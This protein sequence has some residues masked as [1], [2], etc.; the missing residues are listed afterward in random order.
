MET[1]KYAKL[2]CDYPLLPEGYV[3]L[4]AC[5]AGFSSVVAFCFQLGTKAW[6]ESEWLLMPVIGIG[7]AFSLLVLFER[8]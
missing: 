7:L 5:M 2:K 4:G 8:L 3:I 6:Q 1:N